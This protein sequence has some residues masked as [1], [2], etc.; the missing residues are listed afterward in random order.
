MTKFKILLLSF[1][2]S[3]LSYGQDCNCEKN[4]EWVKKTFEENDAG[5][6]YAIDTKGKQEY[7][8]HN[9]VYL[10]K[11]KSAQTTL[12]CTK[13]LYEWMTFFRKGHLGIGI[14]EKP[15]IKTSNN[16]N[17]SISKVDE[18][19]E[20]LNIDLSKFE[21]YLNSKKDVDYEGIW[22]SK[23]YK[24]GIKREGRNYIGFIIES[25]VE[26]WKKG[27]I[28]LR[29]NKDGEKIKLTYYR[30]NR[31]AQE[32]T[33]ADLLGNNYLQFGGFILKR[34]SPKFPTEKSWEDF[35]NYM[36]IGKPFI[37][38]LNKT[39]LILRIP[40][41]DGSAKKN[42][43][44]VLLHSKEKILQTE[45]LIIDLR[46]NDGGSD[47]SFREIL[48]FIYTNPIRIVGV[49][50]YSTKLNNQRML[51]FINKPEYG[52]DEAGKKWAKEQYDKLEKRLGQFVNLE[53]SIVSIDTMKTIYSNPKNV[54]I[55]INEGNASTTEQFLL[56]AKQSK[57]VKLFGTTTMGLL[58]VS[59]IYS[60]KSPCNEFELY[61]SLSRS[62]RIP[63]LT[64]DN[65]GI[66]PDYYIDK[67]VPQYKW[68]DF[69]NEILNTK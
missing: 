59:N 28:K 4:F 35:V 18:K 60:V 66:Q 68:V 64:I 56:A 44:S 11:V 40:S 62:M 29:I 50:F 7:A 15:E 45:N 1:F 69:V 48:P 25:G 54:G 20:T 32:F 61:Y 65:K 46:N 39:T 13:L 5:F 22:E 27:Q 26:N 33:S 41:F 58:D 23:P 21:Q 14:I 19:W 30:G 36:F 17:S 6:Q 3:T 24:I 53:N 55:I 31:S 34:L 42:I 10:Q 9:S 49:E 43:D 16:Q 37:E 47:R 51:D 63:E 2:I 57:K 67:S 8:N 38:E 52:F 12:E